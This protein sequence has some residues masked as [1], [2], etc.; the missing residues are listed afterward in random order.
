MVFVKLSVW[1]LTECQWRV[2]AA[3][4]RPSACRSPQCENAPTGIRNFGRR[5]AAAGLK[6][7]TAARPFWLRPDP[8][9]N[10]IR[11]RPYCILAKRITPSVSVVESLGEKNDV[12]VRSR[13]QNDYK[14]QTTLKCALVRFNIQRPMTS[15]TPKSI[16]RDGVFLRFET[17]CQ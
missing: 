9:M 5:T 15:N 8:G 10:T 3:C 6:H 1:T 16:S 14:Q 11:H 4:W 12:E 13:L 2:A 7:V 17:R